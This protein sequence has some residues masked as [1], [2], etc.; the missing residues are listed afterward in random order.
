MEAVV[1]SAT[2]GAVRILL[3]KLA[4]VLSDKYK[5]LRGVRDEIQE[6]KDELESMNACLRDLSRNAD[7]YSERVKILEFPL[8]NMFFSPET[9]STDALGVTS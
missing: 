6:L 8:L 5:L 1:L 4:D 3:G 2:E 9:D 7:E